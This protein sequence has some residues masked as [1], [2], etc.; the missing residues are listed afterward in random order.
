MYYLCSKYINKMN[1][2][3]I[4]D[5]NLLNDFINFIPELKDNQCYYLCLFARSKYAKNE[6]G[7]NKFPHIKTDKA[8]LKRFIVTD[9]KYML[10]KIKQL[11]VEV[12]AYKTKDGDN[13]PQ[14][15]L[16]LYITLNPRN[17]ETAMFTLM[18]RL[19]DIQV[20][21]GKNY[22][23]HSE[24]LSAIQKSKSKTKYMIFDYD[25]PQKYNEKEFKKFNQK[26][27]S[28]VG[29]RTK[30]KILE[31]RG[32]YHLIFD[33]DSVEYEFK[34]VWYNNIKN[35][36]HIDSNGGNDIMIPVV[37]T[38]QGGFIPKFII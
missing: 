33:V 26:I 24:S 30:Y 17:M 28:L 34:N 37:G 27:I 13:I 15:S 16:A 32:G 22:N 4:A 7:S 12:G 20:S 5:E 21:K 1:Y 3:I 8:Q 35:L 23:I 10:Q 9:K 6:D 29:K 36:E 2:K 19:I 11:E 38:F 14:E 25:F 18:R 31:T